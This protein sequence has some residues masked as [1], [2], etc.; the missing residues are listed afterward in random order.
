MIDDDQDT[1]D[2]DAFNYVISGT[3]T[4]TVEIEWDTNHVEISPWSLE[5]FNDPVVTAQ[6]GKKKIEVNVGA[7][8][9]SYTLQFFRINGIPSGETGADVKRY[10]SLTETS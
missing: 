1:T 3:A 8:A 7:A 2:I 9:Q 5:L 6:D 4:S 10:V